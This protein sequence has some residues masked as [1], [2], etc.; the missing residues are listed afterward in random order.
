MTIS[1]LFAVVALLAQADPAP[2]EPPPVAPATA[3]P[4][5]AAP[6]PKTDPKTDLTTD[7]TTGPAEPAPPETGPAEP[8]PA[9]APPSPSPSP[10]APSSSDED[11]SPRFQAANTV[12]VLG[13]V[14]Y[15][16]T[17]ATL[18][19][20]AG[21]AIGGSYQ[22]RYAML[23]P[24]VELGLAVDFSFDR[25]ATGVVGSAPDAAGVEQTYAATR[26]ITATTFDAM[27]TLGVRVDSF[28][29]WLGAGAGL[30]VGF[31][32]SP[33]LA[34]RPGTANAYQPFARAAA[35]ADV[36]INRQTAVGLRAG[37][38][39]MLSS[40]SLETSTSGSVAFL[41]DLLDIQAWLFYRFR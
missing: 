29:A 13:G 9:A 38:T 33:E 40:S 2:G 24:V 5:T 22:R 7:P 19:P 11:S 6:P 4:A 14:A 37:Y 16:L 32:S 15:R 25:F 3:A 28:H 39:F 35:G 1:A 26:T 27:Q 31:L 30:A 21:F 41:G 20:S 17:S 8:A 23:N 36:A 10:S 34:L 12:A 18:G